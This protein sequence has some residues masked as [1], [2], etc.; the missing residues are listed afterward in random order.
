MSQS[1]LFLPNTVH[2]RIITY[3]VLCFVS[4]TGPI[5]LHIFFSSI[6]NQH[7]HGIFSYTSLLQAVECQW[8]NPSSLLCL[9]HSSKSLVGSGAIGRESLASLCWGGWSGGGYTL[10]PQITVTSSSPGPASIHYLRGRQEFQTEVTVIRAWMGAATFRLTM[11]CGNHPITS[12]AR[13]TH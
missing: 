8:N 10:L 9:T 7:L 13:K 12:F 4:E 2:K 11:I 1:D 6:V 3:W 5:T